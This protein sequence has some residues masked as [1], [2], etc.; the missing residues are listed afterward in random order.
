MGCSC[1]VMYFYKALLVLDQPILPQ[2]ITYRLLQQSSG[3]A[4]M[5]ITLVVSSTWGNRDYQRWLQIA[6]PYLEN[7]LTSLGIGSNQSTQNRYCLVRFGGR[8]SYLSTKFLLVN[9]QVFFQADSFVHARRQLRRTGI[10]ADGY[11]ALDFVLNSAPFRTQSNVSKMV[12]FVSNSERSVLSTHRNITR[13]TIEAL[14]RSNRVLFD[15]VVA[16]DMTLVSTTEGSD[17]QRTPVVGLTG[18]GEGVI[19]G[20]E[21]SFSL[22]NGR[23]VVTSNQ[24]GIIRDYVNLTLDVGGFVWSLDLLATEN[25]TLIKSFLGAMITQHELHALQVE[26]VCERCWCVNV[27]QDGRCVGEKRC[28]IDVD[29]ELCSCLLLRSPSDVS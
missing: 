19:A 22:L 10:S 5:D 14:L 3:A 29:Q 7:R 9:D 28:E 23:A 20:E 12:L 18:D 16:A 1:C 11:Q 4:A 27:D 26:E 24:E 17:S 13:E 6:V 21:F 15:A 8:G 25:I 2:N